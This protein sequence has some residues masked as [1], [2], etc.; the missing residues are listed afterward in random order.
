[1]RYANKIDDNQNDIVDA[2]RKAGATVRIVSQGNGLPDLLVGYRGVTI[3]MEVKD[4][5]K[6]PSARK[7][8]D[9]EDKFFREWTG[10]L[11]AVINSKE[12]ALELLTKVC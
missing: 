1:M 7:L 9:A 2:L 5:N 12:E 4:G 8:T 11:L 6:V 3:L 10:G